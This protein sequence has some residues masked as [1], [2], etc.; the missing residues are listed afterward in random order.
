MINLISMKEWKP[1]FIENSKIPV[2]LSHISPINIG[3]ISFGFWVWSRGA[4]SDRT[5]VHETIHYQ[6]Q[7]E[8]LFVVHWILY[9]LY[10]IIN[11]CPPRSQSG[12]A[13]YRNIP[14]EVEAYDNEDNPD[15]L[16][17]RKRYA[18]IKMK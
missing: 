5:K 16:L 2:W 7:L 4:I 10:W 14:F 13:A 6:Q 3:A 18:W 12:A 11:L 8:L 1:I 17:N 15:Y 9:G